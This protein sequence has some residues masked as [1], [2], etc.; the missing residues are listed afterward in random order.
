MGKIDKLLDK[1]KTN[2]AEWTISDLYRVAGQYGVV[3]RE[4]K[5]SHVVF[6]FGY[7]VL[8][9]PSKRPIKPIYVKKFVALIE[10]QG[11]KYD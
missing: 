7:V 9:V 2:P 11:N 6:N 4:G 1:M 8:T 5:G 10:D 3:Y